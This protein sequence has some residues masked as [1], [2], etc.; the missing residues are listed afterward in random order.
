VGIFS[1]KTARRVYPAGSLAGNIVGFLGADGHGLGGLEASLDRELAGRD[2]EATFQ[3]GAGGRVIPIAENAERP[4]VN[5][6]DVQLTIERDIQYVAETALAKKVKETGAEGGYALVLDTRTGDVLAMATAPGFDPSRPGRYPTAQRANRAVMETYEP[7]ST[8]KVITAAALIEAGAVTPTTPITVPARL[9]R[10]GSSFKDFNAHGKLHLTYAGTLAK[11]SNMGTILAAE[12]LEGGLPALHPWFKR[13]G[14]G[15]PTG[16]GLPG[17]STGSIPAP[18]DWSATTGYTLAFGQGYS[19][20]ALQMASAFATIAN[21]GV[22]L[23]PRII[24]GWRA[25][26]RFTPAPRCGR[27]PG[28]QPEDRVDRTDD[29]GRG[30]H[31]RRHGADGGDPGVPGGGQDR[32]GQP[33]RRQ[34]GALLRLHDVLHRHRPGRRPAT[35]GLG[36][37]AG[38]QTRRWRRRH[39]RPCL[40]RADVLRAAA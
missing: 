31:G 10:G 11:S 14:I 5:G 27:H 34:G 40:P 4:P 15:T 23:K 33:L 18:A 25:G 13:F 17:E 12:R 29:D 39:R 1:E 32:H 8:G 16:A 3:T 2:G 22:R 30:R 26:G 6:R 9:R 37:P 36:D 28:G 38:A 24:A 20:N 7:G 21:D 19:V 35:R